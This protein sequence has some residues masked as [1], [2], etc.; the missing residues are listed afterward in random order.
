VLALAPLVWS[1]GHNKLE[2]G[3]G[4][5]ATSET[6][7]AGDGDAGVGDDGTV[8]A[9]CPPPASTTCIDPAPSFANDIA[10]IL[11]SRCNNCHDPNV[12][13]APWPLIDYGDVFAWSISIGGDVATCAM[14][15]AGSGTVLPEPERQKILAWIVCGSP[16]N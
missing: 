3:P 9:A 1:C 16:D 14:P 12:P 6:P 15:P 5:D 7:V 11:D 8:A 2:S 10:P 13:E 4:G